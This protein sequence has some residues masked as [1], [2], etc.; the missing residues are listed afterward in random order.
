M[1][2]VFRT[3]GHYFPVMIQFHALHLCLHYM[4][5]I[6]QYNVII[7]TLT[8]QKDRYINKDDNCMN[9]YRALRNLPE[10]YSYT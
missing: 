4:N 6:S 9:T 3:D 8:I 1:C 7:S 10:L 2:S 5:I